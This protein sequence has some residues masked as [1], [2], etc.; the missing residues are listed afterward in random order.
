MKHKELIT[1]VI[2]YVLIVSSLIVTASLVS[3]VTTVVAQLTP[4]ERN[5]TIV[6]DAGHGGPDGGAISCTGV[7]ESKF[8]L[9]ISLRL[10]D[11][12]QLLGHKTVMIRTE[13]ESIYISGET[14]AAKKI[15]DLRQ[16]VKLAN[17]IQGGVLVSIHQNTFSDSR[18]S[19]PQVF[20]GTKGEGEQLAKI[21]QKS[22]TEVLSPG[23]NR[24][25]KKADGIYLMQ[26][27]NCTGVL[28]ECGFLSN[29][30]EEAKLRN[31]QYQQKLCCV[32]ASTV[33]RYLSNT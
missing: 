22:L 26:H 10:N 15:S 2:T 9:D 19:G 30:E 18:Y 3:E 21:L 29:P 25:A 20:Y 33:D 4:I 28:I 27:I 11:L 24:M 7:M 12:L 13:D 1:V 31:C 16:R 32:I 17:E 5:H 23:S 6:I 8:N 14:I